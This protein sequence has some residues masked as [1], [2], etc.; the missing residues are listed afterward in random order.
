MSFDGDNIVTLDNINLDN[1]SFSIS[2]DFKSSFGDGYHALMR[3]WSGSENSVNGFYLRFE[4]DGVLAFGLNNLG[5]AQQYPN[6][7]NIVFIYS[8]DSY[9]DDIWHNATIVYNKDTSIAFMYVDGILKDE[10]TI[11][12]AIETSFNSNDLYLGYD[13][14]VGNLD[15][16]H[17]WNIALS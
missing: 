5:V 2:I 7:Q 4:G 15:N 1:T 6:G 14:Y 3:N 10:Q 8:G 12:V 13:G 11:A 16:F 9:S 17:F